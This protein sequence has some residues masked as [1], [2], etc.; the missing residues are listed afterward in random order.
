MIFVCTDPDE[1]IQFTDAFGMETPSGAGVEVVLDK[2]GKVLE[3]HNERGRKVPPHCSILAGVGKGAEWLR[4]HAMPAIKDPL[5][6]QDATHKLT[7]THTVTSG[8]EKIDLATNDDIISGGPELVRNGEVAVDYAADGT[9]RK[10]DADFV[11]IWGKSRH[12]RTLLG[13]TN[14]DRVLLVTATSSTSGLRDGLTIEEAAQLMVELGSKAAMNLDGG[15]STSM[16]DNTGKMITK[17]AD[18]F[19]RPVCN[20]LLLVPS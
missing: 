15:G 18:G 19:E 3:Q 6:P 12:P 9:L 7:V 4:V 10:G 20:A 5:T 16:V 14:D 8:G 11:N 13:F 17:P 1:I 2:D